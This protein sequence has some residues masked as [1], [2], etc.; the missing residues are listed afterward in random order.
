[1]VDELVKLAP[2]IGVVGAILFVALA[3]GH[4]RMWIYVWVYDEMKKSKDEQIEDLTQRLQAYEDK[5]ERMQ[6]NYIEVLR[7]NSHVADK[8]LV[9]ATEKK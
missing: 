1:M 3:I 2:T 9:A 7:V 6:A 4:R 8:A 5:Y